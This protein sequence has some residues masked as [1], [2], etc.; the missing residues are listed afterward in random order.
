MQTPNQKNNTDTEVREAYGR[1]SS[2][3]VTFT[4]IELLVGLC[5]LAVLAGAI[6]GAFSGGLKAYERIQNYAATQTDVVFV[7]EAMEK[8]LHNAYQMAGIAFSGHASAMSFP[9]LVRP[10]PDQPEGPGRISYHF[11]SATGA[12]AKTESDYSGSVSVGRDLAQVAA[13][14]FKYGMLLPENK[15]LAWATSWEDPERLPTCVRVQVTFRQG[16]EKT[17]MV[18]TVLIPVSH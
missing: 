17:Q 14:S 4:L 12:I 9:A 10:G 11:R 15:E 13:V 8:D 7:L 6:L 3:S 5:I 2:Y 1:E 16:E 18:R